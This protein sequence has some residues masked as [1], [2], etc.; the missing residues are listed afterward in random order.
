MAR[1]GKKEVE[2]RFRIS[3]RMFLLVTVA[4]GA[5]VGWL[6]R[7]MARHKR[8]EAIN[9]IY[10]CGGSIVFRE[11]VTL[12]QPY[13]MFSLTDVDPDWNATTVSFLSTN[14]PGTD[15]DL[16]S[17]VELPE[18][19]C[20]DLSGEGFTDAGLPHLAS[21]P[22]LK[23]LGLYYTS[24]T[25]NGLSRFSEFRG[26]Q[27]LTLGGIRDTTLEG[28]DGIG[29]IRHL[30]IVLSPEFTDAGL[31]HLKLLPSIHTL[32]VYRTP[33][34][35]VGLRHLVG[36]PNLRVLRL[37]DTRVSNAAV[38]HLVDMSNLE[39]LSIEDTLIDQEGVKLL[40]GKLEHCQISIGR[41]ETSG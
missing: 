25:M 39:Y 28:I 32:D 23:V 18:V 6:V 7:W 21:L 27:S 30:Q 16:P 15:A 4:C 36:L 10:Q 8:Q 22:S 29:G 2:R 14:R 35:G 38:R 31:A 12:G 33:I 17:L 9:R 1:I 3:L 37:N 5:S 41:L 26:L 24:I 20:V 13:G 11:G 34:D 40:R 19:Q